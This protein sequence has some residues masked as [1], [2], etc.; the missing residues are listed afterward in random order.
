MSSSAGADA[1]QV[2]G[3]HGPA[4]LAIQ[5]VMILLTV[6][7]VALRFLA[8]HLGTAKLWLDDWTILV[9]A[10]FSLGINIINIIGV[11]YGMGKHFIYV[12]DYGRRYLQTFYAI[13]VTYTLTL[14]MVKLGVLLMYKRLFGIDRKFS[15]AV[16]LTMGLVVCWWIAVTITTLLQCQPIQ[17][18]WDYRIEGH[19]FDIMTFFEA[20]AIPNIITDVIILLLPQPIIWKLRLDWS[21]R[22]GVCAIFLLGAFTACT[23]IGRLV[24]MLLFNDPADFTYHAFAVLIWFSLEPPIGIVC[25]CLP[26][27]GPIFR[28]LPGSPFASMY[29]G[30]IGAS[31][32]AHTSFSGARVSTFG[33]RSERRPSDFYAE[34]IRSLRPG[35]A[36]CKSSVRA[37]PLESVEPHHELDAYGHEME[38][39]HSRHRSDVLRD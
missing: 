33:A 26:C 28:R 4:I 19:C 27:L 21:T 6:T 9:A 24:A 29:K 7:S 15:I 14:A 31:S 1:G 20:S 18:L 38:I 23:S 5:V 36:S 11:Q 32:D 10:F 39:L 2:P 35:E 30:S 3:D 25:A 13:E 22:F 37:F 12:S 16:N 17:K 34:S 8:R